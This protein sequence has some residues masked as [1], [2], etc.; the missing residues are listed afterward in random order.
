MYYIKKQIHNIHMH[1]DSREAEVISEAT[2]SERGI[3][4]KRKGGSLL[5]CNGGGGRE[6]N[7]NHD[8]RCQI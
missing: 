8:Y 5:T 2:T 1:T 4:G 7:R 3:Q 6:D